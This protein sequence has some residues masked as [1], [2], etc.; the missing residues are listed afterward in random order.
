M[1]C[2]QLAEPAECMHNELGPGAS[3][4]LTPCPAPAPCA[5]RSSLHF[6]NLKPSLAQPQMMVVAE[7]DEPFVPLPDDLLVPLRE[8]R[9]A[10]GHSS[11]TEGVGFGWVGE[12]VEAGGA[13]VSG[14]G[15][16]AYNV[17]GSWCSRRIVPHAPC[18][19]PAR[20]SLALQAPG[21]RAAGLAA[22]VLCAHSVR[23]VVHGARAAGRLPGH[24]PHWRQAHALP[25]RCALPG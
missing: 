11:G 8:S 20:P 25:G 22:A 7:V 14:P 15:Q 23:G 2:G 16:H 21:G 10:G 17:Y 4:C 13:V 18:L 12:G 24:E 6:Y 9:W 5:P 1:A 3:A 19:L